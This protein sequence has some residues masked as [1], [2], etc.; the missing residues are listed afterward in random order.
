ME[1]EASKTLEVVEFGNLDL[2]FPIEQGILLLGQTKAGK[3]TAAHHLVRQLLDG[4]NDE[5]GN[6]VYTVHAGQ[7]Q[8]QNALIGHKEHNS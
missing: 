7:L 2:D 5:S 8:Y 4:I 6:T 1:S 3:T